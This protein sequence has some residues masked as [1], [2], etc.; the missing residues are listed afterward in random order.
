M[1]RIACP[2]CNYSGKK[3]RLADGSYRCSRCRKD[4]RTHSGVFRSSRVHLP[5]LVEFFCLGVPAY[6]LRFR[7]PL[8]LTTIERAYHEFRSLIYEAAL[9]ELEQ[10]YWDGDI[11]CDEALFGGRAH[12]KRGWGAANKVCVFGIYKRNGKVLTFPVANRQHA[13]ILPLIEAHTAIGSLYYTD[14]YHAYASLNERGGHIVVEKEKGIPK[15]RDHV[16]GIEGYWSYAKHW[17]YPYR[18]VPR[19]HFHLYLKEAEWRFNHRDEDLVPLLRSIL[20]R[21]L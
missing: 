4:F 21:Y 20:E 15:G 7:V 19:Q 1:P 11:E 18:G 2:H 12:G 9:E 6:R 8:D 3:W 10:A 5:R 13:T 17:L 14:D 16:N